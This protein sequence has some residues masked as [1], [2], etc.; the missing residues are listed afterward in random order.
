MRV[1]LFIQA[2]CLLVFSSFYA[3]DIL[4]DSL[5]IQLKKEINNESRALILADIGMRYYLSQVYYDS[6]YYYTEKAYLL[7]KKEKSES[8]EAKSLFYLGLISNSL[9]NYE[10]A[11][12]Y[13]TKSKTI[14]EKLQES[15]RVS[16]TFNNIGGT[17]FELGKYDKAI[18]NY[19][20]ALDISIS[21]K[22]TFEIG[23]A[24]MN[25]GEVY[26][27]MGR[28]EKS[29]EILKLSLE[30]LTKTK[31]K[32]PTV[33][34]FYARTLFEL[35]DIDGAEKEAII[36]LKISNKENNLYY[37]SKSS[38]VL[39]KI[40]SEKKDFKKALSFYKNFSVYNDS[41]RNLK[42]L[43]EIEKLK[44]NFELK[45]KKE[46]L[47]YIIQKQKDRYVIWFLI[48]IGLL[49][50]GILVSRQRKVVRMTQQ[51][52]GVQ[53]RLIE[54]DLERRELLLKQE[55]SISFRDIEEQDEEL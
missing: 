37:I 21:K 54:N 22:D 35:S 33:H 13:Y 42:G 14:S 27:A 17:Y 29:K 51:M 15:K 31:L 11:I 2:V 53:K 32:P 24:Y 41:L 44:L 10:A 20:K 43:N 45:Q 28:F 26:Y 6:A 9:N 19:K 46:E 34:L 3:Q 25:I 4:I 7:A 40:Y 8:T 52:H 55:K 5:Q 30:T 16:S 1:R 36:A 50:L 38:E 23:V 48:S 18:E 39:S 12:D 49:L 47:S